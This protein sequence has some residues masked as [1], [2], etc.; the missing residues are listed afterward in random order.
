[1]RSVVEGVNRL[2]F[3]TNLLTILQQKYPDTE[4]VLQSDRVESADGKLIV[5]ANT[6]EEGS[7]VGCAMWDVSTGPYKGALGPAIK[8]TTNQLLQANPGKKPALFITGDNENPEAWAHIANKLNY[9]LITDD[10]SEE[11]MA[12]NFAD[13]KNPQDKGDSKR[14]GI[15]KKAS[16]STLKSIRSSD[17]ASPRKKQLAHWQINMRQ[18]RNK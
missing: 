14:H 5:I 9:K 13:G 7:Y 15:P 17:T 10:E 4:F 8:Q 6:A 12:E 11:G 3:K 2:D 18:G 1:M 16:I